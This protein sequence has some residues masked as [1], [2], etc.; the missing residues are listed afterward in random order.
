S[1]VSNLSYILVGLFTLCPNGLLG[2][3][4]HVIAHA[5]AKTALFLVAGSIIFETHKTRV[6]ELNGIGKKMPV[7]MWCFTLASLSL[8][9]IPPLSG[10]VS[11]WHLA[12]AALESVPGFV[13]VLIPVVLLISALLTAGY[14]LSVVVAGFFPGKEYDYSSPACEARAVMVVP[15]VCLAAITL[16]AGVFAQPLSGM[17]TGLLG[18]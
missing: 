14:L 2:S 11:K 6:D 4:L 8:I 15:V 9:G 13:G 17:L 16:F 10:F 18:L 5:S 3:L 12:G 7:T 1:T